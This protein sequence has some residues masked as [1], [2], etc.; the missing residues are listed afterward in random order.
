MPAVPGEYSVRLPPVAITTC[1]AR[2]TT[3][4]IASRPALPM[5]AERVGNSSARQLRTQRTHTQTASL[6]ASRILPIRLTLNIS[7]QR[8]VG[9]ILPPDES[10]CTPDLLLPRKQ[11]HGPRHHHVQLDR[12]GSVLV[13]AIG[14][15]KS[16]SRDGMII[17]V[18]NGASSHPAVFESGEN[19]GAI[20]QVQQSVSSDD[21]NTWG[22]RGLVYAA[23]NKLSAGAP[24]V[25]N[26]NGV[27]VR[28][29]MTNE[30]TGV[31]GASD[32]AVK[33]VASG[34]NGNTWGNKLVVV[35]VPASHT[36][37]VVCAM[38]TRS[39]TCGPPFTYRLSMSSLFTL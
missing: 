34:G 37:S 36:G 27:L 24:Q 35:Q 16:D 21:G 39:L 4:I 33:M 1:G 18:P 30:D 11:R 8:F 23:P 19:G 25:D 26:V 6:F 7:R 10:G 2:A 13:V 20:F 9:T 12:R 28:A 31:S 38:P 29:F 14:A 3:L 15:D 5:T 17:I 32:E 22:P